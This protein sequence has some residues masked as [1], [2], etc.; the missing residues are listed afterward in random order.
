MGLKEIYSS[1]EEKYYGLMDVLDKSGIPVYKAIDFL[2]AKNIPSFPIAVILVL[3]IFSGAFIALSSGGI[4]ES[5][6]D[7]E[8]TVTDGIT[9]IDSA[10]ITFL[11]G[12]ETITL[13]TDSKG[14]AVLKVT[15]GKDFS[16]SAEK[17]GFKKTTQT[18]N[19]NKSKTGSIAL[20]SDLLNPISVQLLGKGD[21][22]LTEEIDVLFSC[23]ENSSWSERVSFST[24]KTQ[25]TDVPANCG[26]I[27][28]SPIGLDCSQDCDFDSDSTLIKIYLEETS[29]QKGTIYFTVKDEAG[30]YLNGIKA[31]A[32]PVGNYSAENYCTTFTGECSAQVSFGSYYIKATDSS[33]EFK[34]F[35][36]REETTTVTVNSNNQSINFN[37][38]IME[39]GVIGEIKIRV[40]NEAG[41][42]V[43][44]ALIKLFKDDTEINQQRTNTAGEAVFNVAEAIDFTV[45]V[46]HADY[47]NSNPKTLSPSAS[48]SEFVLQE[49]TATN[50]KSIEVKVIDEKGEAVEDTKVFLKDAVS[51]SITGEEKVT[52]FDGKAVFDRLKEGKYIVRAEKRGFEGAD[53]K[54]IEVK[55]KE[56]QKIEI[57]LNIGQGTLDVL[58]VDKEKQPIQSATIKVIDFFT[59]KEISADSTDIEGRKSF[60]IRAD[61]K[62]YLEVSESSHSKYTTAPIQMF[63]GTEE[64]TI[65][66]EDSISSF[67]IKLEE[68]SLDG[69]EVENSSV[70]TGKTYKAKFKLMVPKGTASNNAGIHIR[71]GADTKNQN[72]TMEKDDLFIKSV[73]A[74]NAKIVK[75]TTFNPPTGY[76]IDSKHLTSGSAKWANIIIDSVKEG[77]YEIEAVIQIKDLLNGGPMELAYRAWIQEQGYQRDPYDEELQESESSTAKQA[78]YAKTRHEPLSEGASSL[79]A[80]NFCS[81]FRVKDLQNAT[82]TNI[83][84]SFPAEISSSYEMEFNIISINEK[85]FSGS[86]LVIEGKGIEL[87]SYEIQ[88]TQKNLGSEKKITFKTGSIS[89]GDKISGKIVFT[90][91]SEGTNRIDFSLFGETVNLGKEKIL[92]KPIRAEVSQAKTMAITTV[93]KNLVPFIKNNL[94]VRITDEEGDELNEAEIKIRKNDL[95]IASG[96]TDSD[97]VFAYAFESM[98]PETVILIKAEKSGFNPVEK[99]IIIQKNVVAFTPTEIKETFNVK[100]EFKVTRDIILKNTTEMPLTVI[101]VDST[102]SFKGLISVQ[103]QDFTGKELLIGNEEQVLLTL[104]MTDKGKQVKEVTTVEGEIIIVFENLEAGKQWTAS[105]PVKATIGLG[106]EVDSPDCFTLSPNSWT[107]LTE[108]TKKE[109]KLVLVNSCKV[110]EEN[111]SLKDIKA[112]VVW[113][114]NAIGSID[115][116]SLIEGSNTIRLSDSY[117]II[118]DSF[119]P[120]SGEEE[121]LSISFTPDDIALGSGTATIYIEAV[122]PTESGDEKLTQKITVQ[123]EISRLS[124]CI[125]IR[126]ATNQLR[127]SMNYYNQGWGNT[128]SYFGYS[129]QNTYS[130]TMDP[131]YMSSIN[132]NFP[133]TDYPYDPSASAGSLRNNPNVVFPNSWSTQQWPHTQYLAQFSNP[134]AFNPALNFGWNYGA[135]GTGSIEI[136]NDCPTTVQIEIEGSA[137]ISVSDSTIALPSGGNKTIEVTPTIFI[138]QYPLT[139]R[140]KHKDSSDSPKEIAKY[141]VLIESELERNYYDCISINK[142]VFEFNDLIQRPVEG[143]IWNTCYDLGIRLTQ[144]SIPR[145]LSGT[146]NYGFPSP[147]DTGQKKLESSGVIKSIELIQLVN[148]PGNDG[149]IMQE[150]KFRMRKNLDYYTLKG[151]SLPSSENPLIELANLRVKLTGL[152]YTVESEERLPVTFSD[153]TGMTQII[154]FDIIIEDLWALS[155]QTIIDFGDPSISHQNCIDQKALQFDSCIPNELFRN[156]IS[157]FIDS[158]KVIY[159]KDNKNPN[160]KYCGDTDTITQIINSKITDES[161]VVINFS[162]EDGDKIKVSVDKTNLTVNPGKI[163]GTLQMRLSRVNPLETKTVTIPFSIE[164]CKDV[165]PL[166]AEQKICKEDAEK[167]QKV[168]DIISDTGKDINIKIQ[169]LKIQIKSICAE[170]TDEEIQA[171]IDSLLGETISD[172]VQACNSDAVTGKTAL[173][174]YGLDKIKLDWN[175]DNIAFNECDS[176]NTYCDSTQLAIELNK[177]AEKIDALQAKELAALCQGYCEIRNSKNLFRFLID[178]TKIK[179]D[180]TG[181]TQI[182][183]ID[184]GY[185]VIAGK[186]FEGT[187]VNLDIK[188][189]KDVLEFGLNAGNAK[190]ITGEIDRIITAMQ[191]DSSI[192]E[193]AVLGEVDATKITNKGKLEAIGADRIEGS[194]DKYAITF[195]EYKEFRNRLKACADSDPNAISC[196]MNKIKGLGPVFIDLEFLRTLQQEIVF[197]TGVRNIEIVSEENRIKIMKEGKTRATALIGKTLEEF[198]NENIEF[199]SYLK[200]DGITADFKTDFKTEYTRENSFFEKWSFDKE[201][202][203][204]GKYKVFFDYDWDKKGENTKVSLTKQESLSE[205]FRQ[206]YLFSTPFDGKVG[207]TDETKR[208]G[209]GTEYGADP[210]VKNIYLTEENGMELKTNSINSA[211]KKLTNTEKTTTFEQAR[212]GRILYISGDRMT[213]SPS[214]PIGLKAVLAGTAGAKGVFYDLIRGAAADNK[215]IGIKEEKEL[216]YLLEW[217]SI[218]DSQQKES[219]LKQGSTCS[220]TR[221]GIIFS[222]DAKTTQKTLSFV[223]ADWAYTFQKHCNTGIEE[224][225]GYNFDIK[226]KA[227]ETDLPDTT[228]FNSEVPA[229]IAKNT[230]IKKWIEEIETGTVCF[231]PSTSKFELQWNKEKLLNEMN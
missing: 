24:G 57:R 98:E 111:I 192:D 15:E 140:A 45:T 2:E 139:I 116:T 188:T 88:E 127:I 132:R 75:G 63:D 110:D 81:S 177:K 1:I 161:G 68:L 21:S 193:K 23:S 150:L 148:K 131:A 196:E 27:L 217:N 172:E 194:A 178:Q 171:I 64:K 199:T 186:K 97:G 39:K 147:Q 96:K 141:N 164:L 31:M 76:G 158:R 226:G 6:T 225:T 180:I 61:K 205:D 146:G 228:S 214:K 107:A 198:Y 18:F 213:F 51:G 3:L 126:P 22:L 59:G 133:F 104:G 115:L 219:G 191:A 41:N 86:E 185:S 151:K 9:G 167:E 154:P 17:N 8:L 182:F 40:K 230:S 155:E 50:K 102:D 38:I 47:L 46:S 203:D 70:T 25:L 206:N 82:T 4:F 175:W 10:K 136:Q 169:E 125:R 19:S 209:Y 74:S 37:E 130:W 144:Q 43:E 60:T 66:L 11:S 48:F 34:D 13:T 54:I 129:P 149:K 30:N 184:S 212:E 26:K 79:C 114:E 216:K 100:N 44:N 117:K 80:E 176:G 95:L 42:P 119:N 156:N 28:A 62:V 163:S 92:F 211:L 138:G 197:K 152:Y 201:R 166:T 165:K 179:D 87:N 204:S 168:E 137:E 120:N 187:K 227:S 121:N 32:I 72:N 160:G 170:I 94:L 113:K 109:L 183:F 142:R 143:I 105:L 56:P 153:R 210:T 215:I 73:S 99:E 65:S 101:A 189:I 16:V 14:K 12:E 218:K 124:Q 128:Q 33:G 35:D 174:K 123:T 134:T 181:T 29:A 122:N 89:K 190:T 223:P 103:V 52:G 83:I 106:G 71:T 20:L 145:D 224:M 112:K 91:K 7:F 108:N 221:F 162:I 67:G 157:Q 159:K 53:S 135:T 55:E 173:E 85:T 118:A 84:D 77:T 222:S 49:A 78:L 207:V 220:D 229:E 208:T 202:L 69:M 90:T 195:N 58:V 5:K 231:V 200:E 36:S 93:P